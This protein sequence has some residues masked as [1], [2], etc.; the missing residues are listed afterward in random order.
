[1]NSYSIEI[2]N[3]IK[4]ENL[5]GEAI[6]KKVDKVHEKLLNQYNLNELKFL[7]IT[8]KDDEVKKV[9]QEAKFFE[10]FENILVVGTGGSSLG[11]KTLS[12]LKDYESHKKIIFIENI[13]T[14]PILSVLEK[15]NPNKTGIIV[16]SKSGETIETLSQFFLIKNFFSNTSEIFLKNILI[17][18]E[19][20][21]SSLR[22]I[23]KE[24]NCR[25]L[26]HDKNIGGRYSIF[27]LVGLLPAKLNNVKIKEFKNGGHNIIKNMLSVENVKLFPPAQSAIHHLQLLTK[28][29]NQFVLMPYSDSLINFSMWF[30]QLWGES[31][32]K[33]GFGSTP[34]NALGTV[35]QHS[36]LQLYLDG[37][38]DKFITL[39][40]VKESLQE[41]ILDC[42]INENFCYD[43]LHNKTMGQLFKA[44]EKAITETFKR[45][46]IPLRVI[47]LNNLDE[48]TLGEL[49]MHFFLETIYTCYLL[50][51]NP[52]DQPAVEEG[53]KLALKFLKE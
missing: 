20:K 44:E 45:R 6:L 49:V 2:F 34:I 13:D 15:L 8:S 9:E 18:T 52:F 48:E 38:K 42:K 24:I 26:E 23:Q 35:D 33:N 29:F 11:G 31:I 39:I 3:E 53:K 16:I 7:S 27:S 4:N 19:D 32:G 50:E 10:N 5:S 28:G 12:L 40:S 47:K 46:G 41:Q 17:I 1:M 37:P 43:N 22:L 30:R 51:I 14:T 25:Y 36:Q 21:D